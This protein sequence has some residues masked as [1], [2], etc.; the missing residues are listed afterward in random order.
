MKRSWKALGGFFLAALLCAPVWGA[1]R[2]QPGTINYVEGQASLNGQTLTDKSVGSSKLAA[3]E[4]LATQNGRVEILL[5]PGIFFRL[6]ANSTVQMVSP[7][8]ADTILSLQHGRALV[9]VAEIRPENNVRVNEGAA[10]VRLLKTGLYEFDGNANR[11]GVFEG[12]AE[13]DVNDR[14]IDLKGGHQLT[15]QATGKLQP[16]KFDKKAD[17]D[18]F[19]RWASLRSSYLAEANVDVARTY[20]AGAWAPNPWY[21]AG[22]Y[23]DPW[24][25]AYTFLPADGIFYGPFGWGFYSPWYV[26]AAPYFGV[27]LGHYYRH[28]GPAYRPVY[29]QGFRA[30]G[31]RG[32]SFAV[33]SGRAGAF[34]RGFARPAPGFSGRSGGFGGGFHGGGFHGGR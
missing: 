19:Y 8:L 21:G 5:E 23:W 7:G 22:W 9:E 1:E 3:G 27:G 14:H 30:P 2:P 24:F 32:H 6:D 13:A 26:T 16:A 17:E 29:A 20:V 34:N 28:F 33:G 31:F 4:T 10:S 18:D 25:D 11:I 12:K 15:L